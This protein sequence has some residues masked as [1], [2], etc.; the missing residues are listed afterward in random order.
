MPKFKSA[1]DYV[2]TVLAVLSFASLV[3][4]LIAVARGTHHPLDYW[5]VAFLGLFLISA[6]IWGWRRGLAPVS[7]GQ[8][9]IHGDQYNIYQVAPG[10]IPA[11][12]PPEPPSTETGRDVLR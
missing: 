10:E 3:V 11:G 6:L 2:Q 1:W 12:A 5:L 8:T 9:V 4:W 7:A